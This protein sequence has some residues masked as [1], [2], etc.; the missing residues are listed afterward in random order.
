MCSDGLGVRKGSTASGRPFAT[1]A[2]AGDSEYVSKCIEG[3]LA[4][5][6]KGFV[7]SEECSTPGRYWPALCLG[8]WALAASGERGGLPGGTGRRLPGTRV[9][10]TGRRF[11][12]GPCCRPGGPDC[13][14]G[15]PGSRLLAGA[16]GGGGPMFVI[17][18][19]I[20]TV[21]DGVFQ[22]EPSWTGGH[23]GSLLC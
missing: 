1:R 7:N 10:G 6:T 5:S 4:H 8:S 19:Y 22:R 21:R 15:G 17:L 18:R 12:G 3:P 9:R 20:H 16:R 14:P 23:Q 2:Q 13:R 11:M